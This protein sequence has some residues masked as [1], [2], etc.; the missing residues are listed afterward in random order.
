[1]AQP[2]KDTKHQKRR[3]EDWELPRTETVVKAVHTAIG[4]VETQSHRLGQR[5]HTGQDSPKMTGYLA[6]VDVA[7]NSH[8]TKA[9][10]LMAL[11]VVVNVWGRWRPAGSFGRT[12]ARR[13]RLQPS[14]TRM[15]VTGRMRHKRRQRSRISTDREYSCRWWWCWLQLAAVVVMA[16]Y[17]QI[18]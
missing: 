3:Y 8:T 17:H 6:E 5:W 7:V 13:S 4:Q 14:H 18:Q 1:L 12:L 10:Q 9:K 15:A 16:H 11:I 2:G